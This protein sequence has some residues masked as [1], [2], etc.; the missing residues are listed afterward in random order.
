L[1]HLSD[2]QLLGRLLVLPTN[3]TLGWKGLLGTNAVA[4]YEFKKLTG[5]IIIFV[6][7]ETQEK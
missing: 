6:V 5:V 2:A 4:Y 7:I 3:I 1:K